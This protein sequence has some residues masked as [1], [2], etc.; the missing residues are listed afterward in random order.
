MNVEKIKYK[1]QQPQKK[2]SGAHRFSF[3]EMEGSSDSVADWLEV[4]LQGTPIHVVQQK[5]KK[6]AETQTDTPEQQ[7]TKKTRLPTRKERGAQLEAKHNDQEMTNQR[8]HQ[9]EHQKKHRKEEHNKEERKKEHKKEEQE[10]QDQTPATTERKQ[11]G[12]LL[13]GKHT[14]IIFLQLA[15]QNAHR[16]RVPAT[17]M[18]KPVEQPAIHGATNKNTPPP[19]ASEPPTANKT[20]PGRRRRKQ[21]D[22]YIMDKFLMQFVADDASTSNPSTM[23][24]NPRESI[25]DTSTTTNAPSTTSNAL[26][27]SDQ[28]EVSLSSFLETTKP[29]RDMEAASKSSGGSSLT[30]GRSPRN[31][32]RSMRS[33]FGR[34]PRQA[35]L[36]PPS[37]VQE[38][39]DSILNQSLPE[40]DLLRP[41][42]LQPQETMHHSLPD[43][44]SGQGQPL[45]DE[46][47][48]L[49]D[50]VPKT[51][52]SR[53]FSL[54]HQVETEWKR[55]EHV[56][57]DWK[58]ILA[59]GRAK[60]QQ[61]QGATRLRTGEVSQ[62]SPP[63]S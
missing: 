36:R 29:G 27:T 56:I 8:D 45:E 11:G 34:K 2:I 53:K 14:K 41:P 47:G 28:S 51:T 16:T 6:I 63:L 25:P 26:M 13:E 50:S 44:S 62:W 30:S 24:T 22:E 61:E 57:S 38:E 40:L 10:Q 18:P 20:P 7:E 15:D 52:M 21:F 49:H 42:S 4:D 46:R 32:N 43:T 23:I 59:K 33:L 3:R 55:H 5:T 1:M 48:P 58:Q 19:T 31:I 54:E 35:I 17:H 39:A 9:K 60:Q 37:M 12:V